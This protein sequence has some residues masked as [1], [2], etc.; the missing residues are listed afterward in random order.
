MNFFSFV[1]YLSAFEK[2]MPVLV[3]HIE[4]PY[5][6]IDEIVTL[7]IIPEEK[8]EDVKECHQNRFKQ[9]DKLLKVLCQQLKVDHCATRVRYDNFLKVLTNTNQGHLAKFITNRGGIF[10]VVCIFV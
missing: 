9:N 2:T 3:V 8:L 10:N 5:G 4:C 6:L 1:D 7:D